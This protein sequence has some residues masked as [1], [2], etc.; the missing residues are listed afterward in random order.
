MSAVA[1]RAK[2]PEATASRRKGR[3][4]ETAETTM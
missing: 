2:Q 3:E 4:R 1:N